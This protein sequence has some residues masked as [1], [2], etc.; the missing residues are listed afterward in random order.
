M[1]KRGTYPNPGIR[2]WLHEDDTTWEQRFTGYKATV[3]ASLER[4]DDVG[5]KIAL[6]SEGYGAAYSYAMA[7]Q[8]RRD[9]ALK[10]H[11]AEEIDIAE[12]MERDAEIDDQRAIAGGR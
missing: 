11:E 4:G 5:V 3:D 12:E 9:G 2:Q 7:S 6:R 8:E 1:A 10:F